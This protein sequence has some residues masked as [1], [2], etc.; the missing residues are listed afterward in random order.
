MKVSSEK[1]I[2]ALLTEEKATPQ[3]IFELS[4]KYDWKIYGVKITG[5]KINL[6]EFPRTKKDRLER[7]E[8]LT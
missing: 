1:F 8:K 2:N 7:V 3:L 5:R 6:D 4:Q